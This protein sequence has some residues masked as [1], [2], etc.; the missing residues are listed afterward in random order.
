MPRDSFID[1][2]LGLIFP[3]R[4]QLC[5]S[6]DDAP[7]CEGCLSEAVLI[8]APDCFYCGVPLQ[9]TVPGGQLCSGCRDGRWMSGMRAVGLHVKTLREA[10]I[11]Y[12]FDGRT[13][14]AAPFGEMLVDVM[15]RETEEGGLPL[16]ACDALVPVPLHRNRRRWRGFDQ[17]ELLC[18]A[19]AE[20]GQMAVWRD[21]LTRVRDTPPQVGVRGSQRGSNVRG[22]FEVERPMRVQ[23]A[24]MILV[25]DVLTTGSTMEECA[26]VLRLAGAAAVYGLTL[27]RG[28]PGWHP[29]AFEMTQS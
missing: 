21:V 5:G 11:R 29:E 23:G 25:D 14:L 9:K 2:L 19:I 26:R 8:D 22:A 28:A 4:C 13:R 24:S 20:T 6:F 16:E 10:I 1:D 7:L 15:A 27:S 17:A 18:D 3:P 12:K